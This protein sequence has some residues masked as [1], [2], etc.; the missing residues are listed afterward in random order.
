MRIANGAEEMLPH[1]AIRSIYLIVF[2][3]LSEFYHV[4]CTDW[5]AASGYKHYK[6]ITFTLLFRYCNSNYVNTH[7]FNCLYLQIYPSN[8]TL[9]CHI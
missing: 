3:F 7:C 8:R 9:Y 2:T 1:L 5:Q 6:F 4:H